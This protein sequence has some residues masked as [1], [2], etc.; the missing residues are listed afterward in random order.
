MEPTTNEYKK[1]FKKGLTIVAVIIFVPLVLLPLLNW[2]MG[3][4]GYEKEIYRRNSWGD[5]SE[6]KYREAFEKKLH[7]IAYTEVDSIDFDSLDFFIERGYKY[8]YFSS[9]KSNFD[10]GKTNYPYQVSHT[11]RTN[12]NLVVYHILNPSA[13]DSVGEHGIVH[14]KNPKLSDT[15][16]MSIGAFKFIDNKARWD[17]IGYIKVFE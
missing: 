2:F 15:L 11:D 10:L 4:H 3:Y 1:S 5:V 6:S 13:P 17:S 12:H 16:L 8:G 7:F 14:L 9:A